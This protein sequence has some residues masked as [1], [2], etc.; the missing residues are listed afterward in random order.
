MSFKTFLTFDDI[1]MIPKFN[2]IASRTLT[3]ISTVLDNQTYNYPFVPANMDTVISKEMVDKI[4]N[5]NGMVIYH[6][7]CTLE[8][9]I[10]IINDYPKVY[11]SVG[12][13]EEEKKTIDKLLEN[14]VKNYCVDVAHGHSE[15]V[16]DIIKYIKSKYD[17]SSIIAGNVCTLE[18]YKYLVN[19]GANIIKV[20]IGS[21]AACTTR[22]KTGFGTPQFSALQECY[23]AKVEL[24]KDGINSWMIADGGI[25][26]PRDACLALAVGADMVMMGNLFAKTFESAG[27][28]YIKINNEYKEILT[29]NVDASLK[30]YSHYRGQ[31]SHNF[32]KSYYGDKKTRVAEGVDF[33]TECIGPVEALIDEYSGSLKSALTYAGSQNL[34]EF[35]NNVEFFQSTSSY[36]PESNHR[37]NQ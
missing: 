5:L 4:S 23:K 18:G 37:S 31:A 16:G 25:K 29:L 17:D 12:I 27:R 13:S 3:N 15:Q 30:I 28:K 9:K 24:L 6:R 26:N 34:E 7:F 35:R 32:M 36:I 1:G 19:C 20:G 11:M 22:M 14:G 10:K 33:Y 2:K 21:G 8:E